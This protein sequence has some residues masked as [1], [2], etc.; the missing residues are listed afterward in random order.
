[1]GALKPA[2]ARRLRA[3]WRSAGW[4]VH[5]ALEAELRTRGLLAA[6]RS[7]G[8]HE[9]LSLTP[10]GIAALAEATE[11][12]RRARGAHEDLVDRVAELL[13]TEGR[14]VWTGLSLR[15]GLP[16]GEEPAAGLEP[17][18]GMGSAPVPVPVSIPLAA[19][20]PVPVS[21][22]VPRLPV[23]GRDL[24]GEAPPATARLRWVLCQPDCFSLRPSTTEAGLMPL[25][26][27]VKA[28]RSDLL[29]DLRRPSKAAAYRALAGACW[30]VLGEGVGDADDVPPP[31][32][33]MVL[34]QGR[35]Q[36]QRP[37]ERQPVR[38]ALATWLALARAT[39]RPAQAS[40][41]QA[42]LGAPQRDGLEAVFEAAA[43]AGVERMPAG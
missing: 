32:G 4:P 42:A 38:L 6:T 43:A 11:G 8:G 10:A 9:T 28:H 25:A 12:H 35:L 41:R 34:V 40:D 18:S 15:A 20:V 13:Q 37:P 21:P 23:P 7:P 17:A 26:H 3:V 1:M 19:P 36:L 24:A 27:E 31:F 16:A 5:D 39:P 22:G 30:Y 2:E 29:A 33:V 14:L